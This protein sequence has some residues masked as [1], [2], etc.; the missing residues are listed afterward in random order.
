MMFVFSYVQFLGLTL[1]QDEGYIALGN[2]V[3]LLSQKEVLHQRRIHVPLLEA[4]V[5]R[6]QPL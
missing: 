3:A 5:G 2:L 4:S 6:H 1:V